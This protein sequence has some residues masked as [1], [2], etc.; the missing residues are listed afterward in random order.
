MVP[1]ASVVV[2]EPSHRPGS[3]WG[4]AGCTQQAPETSSRV[5]RPLSPAIASSAHDPTFRVQCARSKEIFVWFPVKTTVGAAASP[6]PSR[7][8]TQESQSCPRE[9]TV[10]QPSALTHTGGGRVPESS[11]A[12]TTAPPATTLASSEAPV[13]SRSGLEI[14]PARLDR[15]VDTIRR[16]LALSGSSSRTTSG[17]RVG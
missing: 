16:R 1:I 14:S 9:S 10:C 8:E 3:S 17:V 7:R 11:E 13:P 5:S 15:A 4:S 6:D 12:E 2:G